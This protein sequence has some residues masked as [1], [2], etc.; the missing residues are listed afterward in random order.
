MRLQLLVLAS[1]SVFLR[2]GAGHGCQKLVHGHVD[3]RGEI[4][5]KHDRHDHKDAVS[6]ELPK[7]DERHINLACV[8]TNV[9][10]NKQK[11]Q[12]K[13]RIP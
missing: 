6:K 11:Q 9:Q 10:D 7:E 12:Q 5:G 4:R 8:K 1:L 13:A 3:L 2:Q